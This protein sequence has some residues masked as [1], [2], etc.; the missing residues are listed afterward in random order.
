MKV[1]YIAYLLLIGLFLVGCS[2]SQIMLGE[3]PPPALIEVGHNS[4]ETTLGSYCWK[5]N[6]QGICV[7][8]VGPVELLKEIE[9]ILVKAGESISFII[10]DEPMPNKLHALQYSEGV[11][12][13]VSIIDNRLTA[14]FPKGVYYYTIGAWWMDEKV[15]NVAHGSAYYSFVIEVE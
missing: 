5:A 12:T 6:G 13:E 3:N 15:E 8:V 11:E 4:Y 9:P 1:R 10:N 2:S 14:P 7:D